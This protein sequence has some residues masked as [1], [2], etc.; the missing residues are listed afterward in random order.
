MRPLKLFIS[1]FGPYVKEEID[2]TELKDK[3]IFLIHGPT[4]SGKTTI[5]DAMCFALYGDTS[6]N[7]RNSKNMRSHHA[8]IDQITEVT[9]DFEIK[10]YRYRVNRKPEQIRL[11][12]SG[13]GTT[14]QNPEATLWKL[15][16]EEVL[17]QTGWKNV[18][19]TVENLI[20]FKS[21][22]F[23]QVIMLPQGEF[24]KLLLADSVERQDILEKLFSTEIYRRIEEILKKSAKEIK[25]TIKDLEKQKQWLLKKAEC[26]TIKD[27]EEEIKISQEKLINMQEIL[28]EKAEKVKYV[29]EAFIKGKEGNEKLKEKELAQK[30]LEIL[31]D[32]I[33]YIQQKREMLNKAV[34]AATLEETEKSTRLRSKDQKKCKK[35]LE[36]ADKK[37]NEAIENYKESEIKLEEENEKEEDREKLKKQLLLIE[38]YYDKVNAL[39]NSKKKLE[40]LK[41]EL[42]KEELEKEKVIRK[43]KKL[44]ALLE[45]QSIITEEAKEYSLKLAGFKVEYE[46]LQK[47]YNKRKELDKLNNIYEEIKKKYDYSLEEYKKAEKL[48]SKIKKEFF[49]LQEVYQRGQAAILASNLDEN[50]PCPVCGS[51]DHP[52]LAKKED[53][54]PTEEE[55]KE[56][57]L[58]VEKLEKQKDKMKDVVN[59]KELEKEKVENRIKTIQEELGE[60]AYIKIQIL[61]D[62]LQDKQKIFEEALEKS[63]KLEFYQVQLEK[64]KEEEKENKEILERIEEALKNKIEAYQK[65]EGALKEQE[66]AIPEN[67]RNIELLKIAQKQAKEQLDKLIKSFE[68][69]KDDFDKATKELTVAKTS[70]ENAKKALEEAYTKYIQER[71]AFIKKLSE[72]GFLSYTDYEKAKKDENLRKQLEQ[73]IKEFEGNLHA[74]KD[75]LNRAKKASEGIVMVDIVKLEKTL[76]N[77][78]KEKV[79]ALKIEN[80]LLEKIKYNKSLLKDLVKLDNLID[81]KEKEYSVVGKLSEVSNGVNPYGLTFQRFVLSTLLDD[82]TIAATER[83]KLMSKGRYH[84]RRTMDRARKNAAGGLELEVFDTYTGMQRPVSTLSGGET[85]LAS[86]SLALGLSDVVQAYSGGI[87]LDTIFVDEGFGTLDPEALDFAMKT[88][89]DLQKG[90]RL[91]GIISHV[92]ELKERIDARLEV[93]QV[94]KGSVAKFKIS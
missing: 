29:Q 68:K 78:E 60:N 75:R 80:T 50:M 72:A 47:T 40:Q 36:E 69:A 25:E 1:A 71:N 37:L 45:K 5:L 20:G 77:V 58:S 65:H 15:N 48:Y 13:K 70:K 42:H 82:I 16:E 46:G 62:K 33:L 2:F 7:E 14:I 12:K 85:F 23:R 19:D 32:K 93:I 56:K 49:A 24:R 38:S 67:I 44:E 34:Q 28:K 86:L 8:Q 26:E 64:L 55:I 74:A 76:K 41:I 92:P 27:L 54:M 63:K 30:E 90:G 87:S 94:E 84:L 57:Q 66:E 43:L 61:K 35:D 4:G 3:S 89:I 51:L 91:V 21:S 59:K 88:L 31:K 83:L 17:L 18:T 9:F 39:E 52:S 10:G 22:Q 73:E 79:E 81:E 11:K 53:W 6:G